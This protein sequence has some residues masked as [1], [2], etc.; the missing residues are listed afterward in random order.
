MSAP[1]LP[2]D[3][4]LWPQDPHA[5]LGVSPDVL[6]ADLRRAY[7]RLI[8]FYKPEQ[9]PEQFRRIR[10]AYETVLRLTELLLAL[11]NPAQIA[12][13]EE[14]GGEE[15]AG[16]AGGM[17]QPIAGTEGEDKVGAEVHALWELAIAGEEASAYQ[18]LREVSERHAGRQDV[19]L[20]LYWLTSLSPTLQPSMMPFDWL[21]EGVARAGWSMRSAE[22]IHR[23]VEAEPQLAFAEGYQKLVSASQSSA[24][25]IEVMHWRWQAASRLGR[26]ESIQADIEG[27]RPRLME[28]G[29]EP[30]AQLLMRA[31]NYLAWAKDQPIIES[32]ARYFA[33]LEGLEHLHGRLQQEFDQ[34]ESLRELTATWHI[35]RKDTKVPN[36]VL[37]LVRG[38]WFLPREII[39]KELWQFVEEIV[40]D[41]Q[42]WL[43]KLT[44]VHTEGPALFNYLGGVLQ[45][46]QEENGTLPD[47]PPPQVLAPRVA[48]FL[49][50]KK[51]LPYGKIRRQVLDFCLKEAVPPGI[52]AAFATNSL[53][54]QL[55]TTA[56]A[57]KIQ[58]DWPLHFIALAHR[59]F[60][61]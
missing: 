3:V 17:S 1:E 59:V 58:T 2:E 42:Q 13:Q 15:A 50:P 23:E 16:S 53:G 61:M 33:E 10:E 7:T 30:W 47:P 6:P 57:E 4:T 45:Q 21:V 8:R 38:S 24:L 12:A 49:A 41:P 55:G 40:R 27:L 37:A 36:D 28:Q 51:R 43:E 11:R 32:T 22:L 46:L 25:L 19:Y 20:R 31:V 26:W 9:F 52:L 56:L 35:L 18:G 5:L 29:E 34:L 44:L 48:E 60:W 39:R 54:Q 14:A